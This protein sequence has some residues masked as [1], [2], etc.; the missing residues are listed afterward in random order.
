MYW[1]VDGHLGEVRGWMREVL[2]S[3]DEL[4]DLTRATALYFTRAI[5]FWQD[6]DEWLVPGLGESAALFRREGE[7][8]GEALA[9]ISLA[10]ALL[11][12]REPDTAGRARRSGRASSLFREAGDTWGE[13]MALVTIGRVAL[14][15][16]DVRAALARFDESLDVAKR[17]HD[18]LG[19]AIALHHRGWA[20]VLLGDFEHRPRLLRAARLALSAELHH[21][22]GV[23]YGLEG[24]TAVAAAAGRCRAGRHAARCRRGRARAHRASTTRRRSRST[25][26]SSTG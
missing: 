26:S 13:A 24:L 15:M 21:D 9:L 12:S 4:D 5:G 16:Q 17:Q 2:D 7:R 14:L 1:W 10:L 22:E 23:A 8:S 11:A 25:S 19:E 6:P 3:G 20:E 18:D